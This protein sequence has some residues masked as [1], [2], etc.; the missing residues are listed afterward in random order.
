MTKTKPPCYNERTRTDCPRRVVG[1]KGQCEAWKTYQAIHDAEREEIRRR[2]KTESDAT[3]FAVNRPLR[4]RRT[5]QA[6][7]EQDRRR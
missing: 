7:Y 2:K 4:R 5:E 6:R 1:C 3:E